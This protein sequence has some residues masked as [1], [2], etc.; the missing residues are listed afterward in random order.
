MITV[1]TQPWCLQ[2]VLM[3]LAGSEV[4]N[5]PAFVDVGRWPS[6]PIHLDADAFLPV[7]SFI[8]GFRALKG[9]TDVLSGPLQGAIS[10]LDISSET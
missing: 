10:G 6:D 2:L 9:H 1:V 4:T 8:L 7:L 5:Y 3:D